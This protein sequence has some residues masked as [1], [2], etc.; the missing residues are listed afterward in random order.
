MLQK[1]VHKMSNVTVPGG[2]LPLHAGLCIAFWWCQW[3]KVTVLTSWWFLAAFSRTDI[4]SD[5][6]IWITC[7]RSARQMAQYIWSQRTLI[8]TAQRKQIVWS[9]IP[10]ANISIRSWQ[11]GHNDSSSLRCPLTFLAVAIITTRLFNFRLQ[12]VLV[13]STREMMF[14]VIPWI[15]FSKYYFTTYVNTR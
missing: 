4:H 12:S 13:T 6:L 15:G 11:T 3:A 1:L 2:I 8:R 9:H 5:Y 10:T 7:S 14:I